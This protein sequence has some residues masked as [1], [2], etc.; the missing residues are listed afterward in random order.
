MLKSELINLLN[1]LSDDANIDDIIKPY[2]TTDINS[3]KIDDL[4]NHPELKGYIKSEKDRAVTKGIETFKNNNL[5][6]LV[7]EE[8]KKKETENLSPEMI[9]I[10]ELQQ[11]LESIQKEK[12]MIETK[13]KYSKILNEKNLPT[14]LVDFIQ[15]DEHVD[16]FVNILTN[17]ANA[18]VNNRISNTYK[19]PMNNEQIKS[20]PTLDSIRTVQ[21]AEALWSNV[22]K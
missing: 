4:L 2:Y 22:W 9:Q 13:N 10:R 8:L 6:K 5:Q 19:P 21:D 17:Y 7:E 18:E 11:Q 3:L 12:A 14:D 16:K 20:Q 1:E 15:S